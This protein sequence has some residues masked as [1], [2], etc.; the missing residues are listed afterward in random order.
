MRIEIPTE[1]IE[2]LIASLGFDDAKNVL[3]GRAVSLVMDSIETEMQRYAERREARQKNRIVGSPA[4]ANNRQRPAEPP[5]PPPE[6]NYFAPKKN[7]QKM[8]QGEWF[9]Q[10]CACANEY[11]NVWTDKFIA[12]LMDSEHGEYLALKWSSRDQRLM[13]KGHVT[14]LLSEAGVIKG[15]NLAVARAYLGVSAKSRDKDRIREV[16]TFAKYM[17]NGRREPYADWIMAYVGKPQDEG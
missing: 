4:S 12:D 13:I 10:V 7:L 9:V 11:N 17:G 5:P 8:L 15:S 2:Q 16:T 1:G 6:L 14:G 3:T